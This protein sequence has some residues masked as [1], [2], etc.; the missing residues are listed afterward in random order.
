MSGYVP[1]CPGYTC[2]LPQL[3]LGKNKTSF[4]E[5][6]R[7][8]IPQS[9]CKYSYIFGFH[10]SRPRKYFNTI[11]LPDMQKADIVNKVVF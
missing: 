3:N 11:H 9:S 2:I 10:Q 1:E 7:Y 8:L 6:K 4:C 5:W